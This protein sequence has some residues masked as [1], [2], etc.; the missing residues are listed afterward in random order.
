MVV[1]GRRLG[2]LCRGHV[3][4]EERGDLVLVEAEVVE[5]RVEL[6]QERVDLREQRGRLVEEAL[7]RRQAPSSTRV[8]SGSRSRKNAFRSGARPARSISVGDSSRAAGPSWV[9][10]GFVS[11]ANSVTRCDGDAWTR[12]GTSGR[13]RNVSAS[14][15]SRAA[16]A[17]K[18]RF[19]FTISDWSCPWRSVRRREHLAR[20]AHELLR[21]ALLAV[22]DLEHVARVLGERREVAERVVQVLARARRRRGPAGPSRR[23]TP[24]AS[25]RRRRGRSRRAR[26]WATTCPESSS[27]PSGTISPPFVPGVSST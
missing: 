11:F 4:R 19:E 8:I 24:R 13:S 21:R 18:T 5:D 23:G 1:P 6:A 10:S 7:E 20:V 25:S 16:V 3:V 26:P 15:A 14:S 2:R 22:E 27:P 12:R 17:S 9:T